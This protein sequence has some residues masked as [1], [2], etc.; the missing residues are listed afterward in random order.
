MMPP[1][2]PV[3]PTLYS[4]DAPASVEVG[5]DPP[6]HETNTATAATSTHLK[7]RIWL[8]SFVIYDNTPT[9]EEVYLAQTLPL[10]AN[11]PL[12]LLVIDSFRVGR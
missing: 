4:T 12:L 9:A 11:P 1:P 10:L 6:P 3:S 7:V 8:L 2:G 5:V